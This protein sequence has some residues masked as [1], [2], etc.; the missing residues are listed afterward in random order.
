MTWLLTVAA[1]AAIG[2]A[3][4]S[5]WKPSAALDEDFG[6]VGDFA[7]TERSGRTVRKADLLGKV[8]VAA[9]TFTRCAGPCSQVS[10]NM[11]RLQHELAGQDDVL[12]VSFTVD[13]EHDTPAVLRQY[14]DRYGADPRRWLFLTGKQD[15]VYR[16]IGESFRL[17]VE[18]TAGA[19]RTPGNEVLHSTKLIL[20][21]RRGHLRGYFDGRVVGDD[22]KPVEELPRLKERIAA[23]VREQS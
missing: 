3:A 14:A 2:M 1:L 8:W 16:L 21:D 11:A 17:G 7:L 12:L 20:V 13:P 6:A 18:Q 9:F 22:G 10:G 15:E 5:A 4:C 23:L 19:A